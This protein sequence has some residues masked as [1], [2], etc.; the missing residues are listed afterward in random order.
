MIFMC[1]VTLSSSPGGLSMLYFNRLKQIRFNLGLSARHVAGMIN[2]HITTLFRH[3]SGSTKLTH[4][5]VKAYAGAY[6]VSMSAILLP[7][8]LI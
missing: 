5:M 8:G 4:E 1:T 6:Q 7:E 3:E 2:V